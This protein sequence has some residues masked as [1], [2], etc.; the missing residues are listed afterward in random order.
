MQSK[1]RSGLWGQ[2]T[3]RIWRVEWAKIGQVGEQ[4]RGKA[5]P[6]VHDGGIGESAAELEAGRSPDRAT[7][8]QIGRSVVRVIT[9][10]RI[11]AA[12][13]L[14]LAFA[15]LAVTSL[16]LLA[17]STVIRGRIAAEMNRPM[18]GADAAA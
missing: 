3:F 15:A 18:T 13:A 14:L 8:R 10:K 5:G 17:S 6:R 9:G 16:P 4:R 1:A 2:S 11:L 7:D 12:T